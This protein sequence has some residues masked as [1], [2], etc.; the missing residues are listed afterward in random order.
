MLREG[1]ASG[2]RIRRL[3]DGAEHFVGGNRAAPGLGS[4]TAAKNFKTLGLCP[5]PGHPATEVG[6][7]DR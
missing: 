4:G 5:R 2:E 7:L 6:G 1:Y 3:G